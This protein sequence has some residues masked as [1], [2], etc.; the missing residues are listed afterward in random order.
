MSLVDSPNS[1]NSLK[2]LYDEL[3]LDIK[4]SE[5]LSNHRDILR[6]YNGEDWREYMAFNPYHYNRIKIDSFSNSQFEFIL[7][8][9][10]VGQNS[11]IHDHPESGCLLKILNGELIEER[12]ENKNDTPILIKSTTVSENSVSYMES[13]RIVHRII[14]S[15]D[16]TVSLHIY[17][18]PD[19]ECRCY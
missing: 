4:E 16:R 15:D 1:L 11:P 17:S 6:R 9:W 10:D 14:N 12:Y 2:E 5:C 13:D 19:Y 3:V 8:C 7:I 18:P